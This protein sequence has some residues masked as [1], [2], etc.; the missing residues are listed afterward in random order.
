MKKILLILTAV[1]ALSCEG[2]R[3]SQGDKES[4]DTRAISPDENVDDNSG[5]NMS[6]QREDSTGIQ[7]DTVRSSSPDDQKHNRPVHQRFCANGA[8]AQS[9]ADHDR[10]RCA[11]HG[12]DVPRRYANAIAFYKIRE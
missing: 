12:S 5:G 2:N 1:L 9:F 11:H 3:S 6:P 4:D 7:A 10:R 8:P